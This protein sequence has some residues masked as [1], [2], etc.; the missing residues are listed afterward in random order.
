M[1]CLLQA[2]ALCGVSAFL[3]LNSEPY[4]LFCMFLVAGCLDGRHSGLGVGVGCG[5]SWAAEASDGVSSGSSGLEKKQQTNREKENQV[6]HTCWSC[7]PDA[8]HELWADL[9]STKQL[10]SLV[11]AE[12]LDSELKDGDGQAGRDFLLEDPPRA[13]RFFK[14][15]FIFSCRD[16]GEDT[17]SG[18]LG[19]W[20]ITFVKKAGEFTKE[21]SLPGFR[22]ELVIYWPSAGK[23]SKNTNKRQIEVMKM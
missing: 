2:V 6:M 13:A 18:Y 21:A 8:K 4:F 1:L 20:M 9:S 11:M 12:Q 10:S 3:S 23:C 22:W 5:G 15:R 7:G 14:S 16:K 17:H 19:F